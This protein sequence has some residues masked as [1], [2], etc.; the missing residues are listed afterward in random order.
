MPLFLG[1]SIIVA[2]SIVVLLIDL[3]NSKQ[4]NKNRVCPGCGREVS[5]EW[6]YCPYCRYELRDDKK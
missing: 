6:N 4:V 3:Y 2:I 5:E 1:G